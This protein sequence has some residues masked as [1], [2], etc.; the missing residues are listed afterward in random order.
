MH[1][2]GYTKGMDLQVGLI[3]YAEYLPTKKNWKNGGEHH[4]P[5]LL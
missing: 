5:T 4:R 3:S 2:I 1:L